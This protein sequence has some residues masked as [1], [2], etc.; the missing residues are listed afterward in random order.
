MLMVW[1]LL[2][3]WVLIMTK[4]NVLKYHEVNTNLKLIHQHFQK[5]KLDKMAI[6]QFY[7]KTVY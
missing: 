3:C 2:I 5:N 6:L 7:Y 1:F 4:K